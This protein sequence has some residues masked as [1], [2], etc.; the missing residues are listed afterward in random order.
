MKKTLIWMLVT[1]MLAS[2]VLVSCSDAPAAED[3]AAGT[4][5]TTVTSGT[6]ENIS[7]ETVEE[8]PAYDPQIEAVDYE[9]YEFRIMDRSPDSSGWWVSMDV[10]SEGLNG[11]VIN[12]AVF[13]R[14]ETVNEYFNIKIQPYTIADGTFVNELKNSAAANDHLVDLG[15]LT[16][17]TSLTASQQGLLYDLNEFDSFHPDAPYY[18]HSILSDTSILKRNYLAV[19]DMTLVSNEGTWSMM[20]NKQVAENLHIENLY[21]LVRE[22]KWTIDKLFELTQN[23]GTD[24]GNGKPDLNDF[25]GLLTTGDSFAGFLYALDYKI[26]EKDPDDSLVYRGMTERLTVAAEKMLSVLGND[27]ITCRGQLGGDWSVF[28]TMF[29]ANQSLF[30]SE[31]LQCV[32]RLR[33]MDVDFGLLPLPKLD[34]AQDTYHTNIHSWA[35]D[36]LT[37]PTTAAD[38]EMASKVFEYLSFVSMST[39]KPAYYDKALT[40]KAMRD[41]ESVEMLDYLLD[42]RVVDIGYLMNVGNVYNGLLNNLQSGTMDFASFFQKNQKSADKMLT[43]TME[44]Y[45][46]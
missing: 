8:E 27:H 4:A 36:A 13:Q 28:Q 32:T 23:I 19:G 30:Y 22:G 46:E 6:E 35:S 43:R 7:E 10:Y 31:V 25:F 45:L 3:A 42:G 11:E 2:T 12:D 17:A 5:D 20:Y 16:L 44:S 24:D 1:A 41:E 9:G 26:I 40:Y 18:T 39:L 21:D 38:P 15:M 34:E 37:I 14:N 29:E 33:N